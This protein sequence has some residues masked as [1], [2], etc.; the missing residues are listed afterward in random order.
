MLRFGSLGLAGL[1]VGG[2][3]LAGG[4]AAGG[5]GIVI[6]VAKDK[7]PKTTILS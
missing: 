5:I 3:G 4:P 7:K 6:G 1:A 2:R